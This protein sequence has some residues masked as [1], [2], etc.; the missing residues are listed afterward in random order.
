MRVLR[1]IYSYMR[2]LRAIY[3]YD[4][5]TKISY[6]GQFCTYLVETTRSAYEN[7]QNPLCVKKCKK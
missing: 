2:V 1:V 3:A 5:S 6:T 7:L 4:I